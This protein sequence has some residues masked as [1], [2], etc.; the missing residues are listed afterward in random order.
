MQKSTYRSKLVKVVKMAWKK[1]QK[2]Q[3]AKINPCQENV[4]RLFQSKD[5]QRDFREFLEIIGMPDMNSYVEF[6]IKV[7]E[8]LEAK[9]ENNDNTI[10]AIYDHYLRPYAN[11]KIQIDWATSTKIETNIKHKPLSVNIFNDAAL[12]CAKKLQKTLCH[13]YELQSE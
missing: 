9:F 6:I 13:F 4:N 3:N 12:F 10:L 7:N 2:S 11:E 5:D 8:L 1:S